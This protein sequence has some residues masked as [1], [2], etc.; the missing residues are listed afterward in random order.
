M[1]STHVA[2]TLVVAIIIMC[3]ALMLAGCQVPL[4]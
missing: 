1:T 2:L 3:A 4:R